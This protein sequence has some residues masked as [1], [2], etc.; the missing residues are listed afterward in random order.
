M[1]KSDICLQISNILSET[2]RNLSEVFLEYFGAFI[3]RSWARTI[4]D[5]A[6]DAE[7]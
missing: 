3:T 1:N 7:Y 6:E 2:I 4:A 5:G